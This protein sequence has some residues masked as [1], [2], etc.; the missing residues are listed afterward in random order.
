MLIWPL[1]H[2]IEPKLA[3][4]DV[5][6]ARG[7]I[8]VHAMSTSWLHY[9]QK[10]SWNS[11]VG[12]LKKGKTPLRL[13]CHVFFLSS[14]S[15]FSHE[16]LNIPFCKTGSPSS[17]PFFVCVQ[18]EKSRVGALTD[19]LRFSE[20]KKTSPRIKILFCL[21][22]FSHRYTNCLDFIKLL[23]ENFTRYINRRWAVLLSF[24]REEIV[25]G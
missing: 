21:P 4:T 2:W 8:L 13:S 16:S 15:S 23:S 6:R 19:H 7:H 17:F 11:P 12:L 3:P 24:G 9:L 1:L 20:E 10:K 18:S 14:S 22:T 25:S 5:R